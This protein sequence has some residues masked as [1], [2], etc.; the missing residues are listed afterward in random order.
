MAGLSEK[1]ARM[2]APVVWAAGAANTASKE[3]GQRVVIV[4][5]WFPQC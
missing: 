3:R 2:A 1:A 4:V 5:G